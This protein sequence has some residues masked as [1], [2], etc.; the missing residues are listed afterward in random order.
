[1]TFHG[2]AEAFF[3]VGVSGMGSGDSGNAQGRTEGQNQGGGGQGAGGSSHDVSPKLSLDWQAFVLAY[4]SRETTGRCVT[5][6]SKTF[7]EILKTH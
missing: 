4:C 7:P 2:H 6:Q 3:H 1:V 5:A